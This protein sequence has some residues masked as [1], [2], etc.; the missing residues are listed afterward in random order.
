MESSKFSLALLTALPMI[1]SATSTG[2]DAAQPVVSQL[3]QYCSS[4]R[5]C[6]SSGSRPAARNSLSDFEKLLET[7]AVAVS[8]SRN[9]TNRLTGI[10][11]PAVWTQLTIC[12]STTAAGHGVCRMAFAT[13]T[14]S[15]CVDAIQD[16]YPLMRAAAPPALRHPRSSTRRRTRCFC[17]ISFIWVWP[18]GYIVGASC[19]AT[20]INGPAQRLRG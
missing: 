10:R 11:P 2:L 6:S 3:T 15:S 7:P 17:S 13:A 5:G 9:T 19:V 20:A 14:R 4:R 16:H 18:K 8:R 1:H 12:S